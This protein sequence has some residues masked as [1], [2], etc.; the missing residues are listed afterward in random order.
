M[1]AGFFVE[2]NAGLI[3]MDRKV[4]NESAEIGKLMGARIAYFK[5]LNAG[6]RLRTS[7][8]QLLSGGD[9]IAET[10][11]YRDP[12][13]IIPYHTCILETN[14][15][16]V[17]GVVIPAIVERLLCVHFPVNFVELGPDEAPTPFRRQI[18]NSLKARMSANY[19]GALTWLVQGAVAWYAEGHLRKN[20]PAK[21]TEFSREYFK[22][23]D[24]LAQF[25]DEC[26]ELGPDKHV[27]TMQFLNAFNDWASESDGGGRM[28]DKT[29]S[30]AMSL[31]GFAK[32]QMRVGG[33]RAMHYQGIGVGLS[34]FMSHDV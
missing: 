20:T 17:L 19:A 9:A 30:A 13:T 8:V 26:C 6:E 12:M 24:R 11:K 16:P 23:Q 29:M 3:T 18:D 5:D 34:A 1:L 14:H 28:T 32:T 4:A 22:D 31:K 10:P 21:V 7:L 2:M 27:P 25:M 15:M 33:M